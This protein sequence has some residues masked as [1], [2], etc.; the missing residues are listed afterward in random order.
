M[1]DKS[2]LKGAGGLGHRLLGRQN[3]P[4]SVTF[5]LYTQGTARRNPQSVPL[6]KG[7]APISLSSEEK[8]HVFVKIEQGILSTQKSRLAE[9]CIRFHKL[10]VCEDT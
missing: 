1:I 5:V 10:G 7:S 9:V 3:I 4:S 8:F 6:K 2:N